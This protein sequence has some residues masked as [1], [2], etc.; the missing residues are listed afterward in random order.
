MLDCMD[1][2]KPLL[3]IEGAAG[4]FVGLVAAL[5]DLNWEVRTVLVVFAIGLVVHIAQ[6]FP[7]EKVVTRFALAVGVIGA[8][9][10]VTWRPIW[11]GFHKDFPEVGGETA[12]YR[13]IQAAVALAIGVA[14]NFFI[15]RPRGR[16]WRVIP[17]QLIAL[18]VCVAGAGLLAA[19]VGVIWQYQQNRAMGITGEIGPNLLPGPNRPQ[20]AQNRPPPALP[21]PAPQTALPP[22]PTA[23]FV[24]GYALT[25][26]GIRA[27]ADEAFKIKDVLPSLTVM[28]QSNE[29]SATTL[30]AQIVMAFG[31]GGV[32][33]G[34]GMGQLGGPSETG[35]IILSD[36]PEHLP[37]P[38]AALKKAL[39][40]IGL[41]VNVIQRKVGTFQFF[42]G[43]DPNS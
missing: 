41:K 22:P 17:A 32:Q 43:P 14:F 37:P 31:R 4:I 16:G 6:R 24:S 10:L 18:G 11:E 8:L 27:L 2:K 19:L 15:I 34:I 12:L 13:I 20:I 28:R 23:P 39:E 3:S 1:E 5:A 42:V 40:V 36:D 35:L 21:P 25:Q 26:A 38:A 9:V 7:I 29:N 33:S 30:A